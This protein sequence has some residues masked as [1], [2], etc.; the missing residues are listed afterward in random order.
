MARGSFEMSV[1]ADGLLVFVS[2][3]LALAACTIVYWLKSW[4]LIRCG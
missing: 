3:R 1:E 4:I 2:S